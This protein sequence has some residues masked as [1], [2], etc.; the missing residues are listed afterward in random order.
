MRMYPEHQ[1][2]ANVLIVSHTWRLLAASPLQDGHQTVPG[3]AQM[4]W[5]HILTNLYGQRP[6]CCFHVF[7]A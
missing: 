7:V 3:G 1:L 5:N 6:D 4:Q 2:T